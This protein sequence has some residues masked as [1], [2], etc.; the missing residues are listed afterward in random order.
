V[1]AVI[2]V[3]QAEIHVLTEE[4]ACFR[5]EIASNL[6]SNLSTLELGLNDN[7]LES[8]ENEM[9]QEE[10]KSLQQSLQN[11]KVQVFQLTETCTR[12]RNERNQALESLSYVREKAELDAAQLAEATQSQSELRSQLQEALLAGMKAK[13]SVSEEVKK[14]VAAA[15]GEPTGGACTL[16][17][18][19]KNAKEHFNASSRSE[20][21]C[22]LRAGQTPT[23][24]TAA[25]VEGG[26]DL[27]IFVPEYLI[28]SLMRSGA[29]HGTESVKFNAGRT[30]AIGSARPTPQLTLNRT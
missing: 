21:S 11:T 4:N 16:I 20:P 7:G 3:L 10:C 27:S 25:V 23:D 12:L 19:I 8:R 9:L 6:A 30:H 22:I 26:S 29:R 17:V 14:T 15:D 5:K 1:D 18:T 13:L 24:K 28:R 2:T